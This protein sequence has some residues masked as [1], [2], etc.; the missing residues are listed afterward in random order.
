MES[1]LG[2]LLI[3]LWEASFLFINISEPNKHLKKQQFI[4]LHFNWQIRDAQYDRNRIKLTFSETN[5][6][7]A[8]GCFFILFYFIW[9]NDIIWNIGSNHPIHSLT[10]KRCLVHLPT[11]LCWWI[12]R[13]YL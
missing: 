4:P 8:F 6:D 12:G 11:L 7:T 5:M 3:Y 1:G 13:N 10:S 9:L 2:T